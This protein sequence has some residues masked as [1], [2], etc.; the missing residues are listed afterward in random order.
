M[1]TTQEATTYNV[2]SECRNISAKSHV[3]PFIDFVWDEADIASLSPHEQE[4]WYDVYVED[5]ELS[6]LHW[7]ELK[8]RIEATFGPHGMDLNG[9]VGIGTC[10]ICERT[11]QI[12][13][14]AHA[15]RE[16]A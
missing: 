2:C 11:D 8:S 14:H 10:A 12:V 5:G 9:P 3:K 6:S 1:T 13:Q 4:V 15:V 7:R 16:D